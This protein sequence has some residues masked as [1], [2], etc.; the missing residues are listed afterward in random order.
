MLQVILLKTVESRTDG[1]IRIQEVRD[2]DR[3]ESIS[4]FDGGKNMIDL[5]CLESHVNERILVT[6]FIKEDGCTRLD[7]EAEKTLTEV[8]VDENGL[9]YIQYS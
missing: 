6:H 3:Q 1:S 4:V 8:G 7:Y 2:L 5:S 9:Q